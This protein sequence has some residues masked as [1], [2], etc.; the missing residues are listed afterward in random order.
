MNLQ[1]IASEK[2]SLRAGAFAI[3]VGSGASGLAAAKLLRK[4]GAR[5]RLVDSNPKGFSEEFLAKAKALELELVSGPHE[6]GQFAGAALVVPSPG[7]SMAVL[8]PLLRKAG[9][10]PCISEFGLAAYFAQEPMI[11]VTGTSGKT[12]TVSLIAAML[13]EAGK[14][15]FLGG[16]IGTP[17]SEYIVE[18]E[19]GKGKADVLVLEVSSFQLQTSWDFAPRV[20][21]LLNLSE[22]HL[23]QHASMEEYRAAKLKIFTQQGPDDIAIFSATD[24]ELASGVDT[25]A[26]KEF[27]AQ[28]SGDFPN[29]CLL[30]LHNQ[31]NLNAAWLAVRE[32]G[33]S[34]AQAQKAAANFQPLPHRM[35]SLGEHNG[36]LYVNDSKCTTVEALRA[37]LKSMD[38]PVV[39]LAGGVFKGGDLIS[40]RPLL[41]E[42]ARAIALF[43][44]SREHFELAW[45]CIVPLTWHPTLEDAVA[46]ARKAAQPGDAVLLS[47]ATSSFD[48]YAN[49]KARGNDFR[50][51]VEGIK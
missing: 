27:F 42:K 10:P 6:S 2:L 1:E 18:N 19:E 28:S 8:E 35:E 17:L 21:V 22:N 23:D 36:V 43:G 39:L 25:K 33:V 3:V 32:F 44:A 31:A 34:L 51:L 5:V 47:P 11:A 4:L 40:L 24:K 30:G 12:T 49:Y 41:K 16:N 38:R 26:C 46:E 50:R 29:T 20:A 9:N 37:A 48:L 15:V 14:K 13:E 7:V 45:E